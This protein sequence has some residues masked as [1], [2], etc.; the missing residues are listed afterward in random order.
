[1]QVINPQHKALV[2]RMEVVWYTLPPGAI[3]EV[4]VG[5]AA[6]GMVVAG[7]VKR[8]RAISRI[9]LLQSGLLHNV[10]PLRNSR[11]SRAATSI[12]HRN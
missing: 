9:H 7:A 1:M 4:A 6:E 11:H 12:I 5:V 3:R 2:R 8:I 10:L